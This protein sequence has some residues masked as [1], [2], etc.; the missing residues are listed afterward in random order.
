MKV[1]DR[2]SSRPTPFLLLLTVLAAFP[3]TSF[4]QCPQGSH[5]VMS[6]N[7]FAGAGVAAAPLAGLQDPAPVFQP[8]WCACSGCSYENDDRA[9]SSCIINPSGYD[10]CKFPL[11]SNK[12]GN[13]SGWCP[14]LANLAIGG[15]GCVCSEGSACQVVT[16]G[17]PVGG[18]GPTCQGSSCR[19]PAGSTRGSAAQGGCVCPAVS[20]LAAGPRGF[21]AYTG[22]PTYPACPVAPCAQDESPNY[23]AFSGTS[24]DSS[25][26]VKVQ[27]GN[28]LFPPGGSTI[29]GASRASTMIRFGHKVR[30]TADPASGDEQWDPCPIL[31]NAYC[32]WT[33]GPSPT[34]P[35]SFEDS[36]RQTLL[37]SSNG[38]CFCRFARIMMGYAGGSG[39]SQGIC[40]GYRGCA[41]GTWRYGQ[42]G[43]RTQSSSGTIKTSDSHG[44]MQRTGPP[45][46]ERPP[47]SVLPE[48]CPSGT[49]LNPYGGCQ[50]CHDR[51]SLVNDQRV[52][53]YD[54]PNCGA[55]CPPNS[56][57]YGNIG[58]L[59]GF[60]WCLDGLVPANADGSNCNPVP[61]P[62][63]TAQPTPRPT[64]TTGPTKPPTMKPTPPP[65]FGPGPTPPP[66]TP[67]PTFMPIELPPGYT[68]PVPLGYFPTPRPG[69][70]TLPTYPTFPPTG[71]GG[72]G[73]DGEGSR[74][75]Q[76][77]SGVI[78]DM[79]MG[80]DSTLGCERSCSNGVLSDCLAE[81]ESDEKSKK[82]SSLPI[83]YI[84]AGVG[85]LLFL[86][87]AFYVWRRRRQTAQ[88]DAMLA[89]E[90][91]GEARLADIPMTKADLAAARK[92]AEKQGKTLAPTVATSTTMYN[93]APMGATPAYGMA[94]S[95]A[96]YQ[97]YPNNTMGGGGGGGA[98]GFQS[99]G[100]WY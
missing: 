59:D 61:T 37:H 86:G 67:P 5:I 99:N 58:T 30:G 48:T 74:H 72:D 93:A 2:A 66:T 91:S 75:C 44:G 7:A 24:L 95:P 25:A 21:P 54:F 13:T 84:A 69:F 22:I 38:G 31:T 56:R 92:V 6:S 77:A 98:G 94:P 27:S 26:C 20:G 62:A 60:C 46:P 81:L 34:P 43:C 88:L 41:G 76:T 39:D 47:T 19:C 14:L 10:R 35:C 15:Q 82:K 11:V 70:P 90:A 79:T 4:A 32:G 97:A 53:T 28:P 1:D 78:L 89:Q 40:G 52:L 8:N 45:T 18:E 33:S 55:S 63:P 71:G 96:G 16:G 100:S 68:G 29:S 80:T 36:S 12:V 17:R 42:I 57:A 9:G 51:T 49:N 87:V 23:W 85:G 3:T 65:T 64:Y 83:P 50:A 73:G